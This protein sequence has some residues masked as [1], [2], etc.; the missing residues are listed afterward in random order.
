MELNLKVSLSEILQSGQF[1]ALYKPLEAFSL[2]ECQ[3]FSFTN[4][5]EKSGNYCFLVFK[6]WKDNEYIGFRS[7][8]WGYEAE[9]KYLIKNRQAAYDKGLRDF[10]FKIKTYSIK[11]N[12][13]P[14][15]E[16]IDEDTDFKLFLKEELPEIEEN[17]SF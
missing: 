1:D 14:N 6:C 3:F 12:R 7:L 2:Y 17:I 13:Y 16:I 5:K 9:S 15:F 4:R 10:S 11:Q 8:L